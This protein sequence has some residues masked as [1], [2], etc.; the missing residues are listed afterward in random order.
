MSYDRPLL[1]I[2]LMLGFCVIAPLGDAFAKLIGQS[3]AVG[4]MLFLR[5]LVQ[6]VLL[7]PFIALSLRPWK[8]SRRA[9]WLCL[10]RTV[11]HITGIGLMFTALKYIPL[12]DAVAIVFV[13]PF[14]TLLLGWL[15]L[16]EEVGP[17]RIATCGVGFA[18]TLMVVQPSFVQIGWVATLPLLVALNF[19]VFMLITRLIARETDPIGL[20]FVSGLMA[21][22]LLLP[23]VFLGLFVEL[24]TLTWPQP[25]GYE[26][27]LL[28][29]V[30]VLGTLA[31]LLMTWSLRFAPSTTV[32]PVQY[33]EIPI[34][35][36]VGLVLFA[37]WPNPLAT[38][39]MVVTI[40]AG[41]FMLVYEQAKARQKHQAQPQ[42][43]PAPAAAE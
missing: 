37:E 1:G 19:A 30:G 26:W 28:I 21:T 18:G 17:V 38:L 29:G 40:A 13:L 8:L 27:F 43:P 9:A 31:H 6:A 24:P 15:F 11:L 16:G 36:C 39:G 4:P 33:V 35:A 14:I 42:Q 2:T 10:V 5:F 41:L 23:A 7:I 3:I 20:Q 34:A 25:T 32:T 22:V 12:A